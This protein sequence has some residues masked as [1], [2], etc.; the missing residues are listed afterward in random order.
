MAELV[1]RPHQVASVEALRA[2]FRAGH[3]R[4]LLYLATGG[5][6][7]A[8]ASFMMREADRKGTKSCF[9]VDRRAI[10]NQ[11]SASLLR[12][13]IDHGV[14]MADH[15]RKKP[16]ANIQIASAQ[17]L[18]SRGFYPGLS[19]LVPDETHILRASLKKFVETH[20]D[21]FVTGLTATPFTP[22]LSKVYTNVVSVCTTDELVQQGW[23]VPVT[24]YAAKAAD[25]TGAKVIAGEWADDEIERRGTEI[26]GD[27]VQEWVAKTRQH[28]GG[29]VK[30]AVF[31]ATVAHG[32]ELCRQFQAAGYLF[33]QV[34][35]KDSNAHREATLAEFAKP[36]SKIMGLVSCEALG[37]GWDQVDILCGIS[38]R[39]YRKSFSS[40]IQQLGRVMRPSAGKT[41][42]L[43][44]DHSG[45]Y[46]RFHKDMRELFANGVTSLSE[47]EKK[48]SAVRKEPTEKERKEVTCGVCKAV[49]LP[50]LPTC[51]CCG[52]ARV[53][54]SLVEVLPG[55]LVPF[56][57]TQ[58]PEPVREKGAMATWTA[59]K[60]YTYK[61]LMGEAI[62]RKKGDVA[63][64]KRW[65]LAHYRALYNEWP[66]LPFDATL[67]P[68]TDI[69]LRSRVLS[70]TIRW[71]HSPF[72]RKRA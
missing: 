11:T 48:D 66:T 2:G 17:T 51:P 55:E 30:T 68:M 49:L 15:P 26:I 14:I 60:E 40:H 10:V 6:K 37:R 4:Q 33:E 57:G 39:P 42:A 53:S 45:N 12:Y 46:V 59:D 18:E 34:S 25:M 21:L 65:S 19:L 54:R 32:E 23:L 7:T 24:A 58:K 63:A 16:S 27:I 29:P 35:Y 20:P 56:D 44:L 9:L 36:D 47:A 8:I 41:F 70:Q 38:A 5:G 61:Q 67:P 71:A 72:P 13:G 31:S 69:S 52:A 43:W 1:L 64:A 28:F 22:G 3:K 50:G 62:Q